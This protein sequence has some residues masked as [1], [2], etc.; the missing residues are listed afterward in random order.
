MSN[1]AFEKFANDAY[2]YWYAGELKVGVLAGGIPQD[3]NV[4]E[5]WIKT[6]L[7]DIRS[8]AEIQDVIATTMAEQGLSEEDAVKE[9][10][11]KMVGMNGFKRDETGLYV[12][13]RQL[14]AA[15]KEAVMVAANAG[16]LE[17][18]KWGKPDN[19]SY[20][21]QIKGWF[22]EHFF[23]VEER[24]YI[25]HDGEPVKVHDGVTQKFV[26]THRGDSISYEQ[27]V[28]DAEVRFTIKS[29]YEMKE[30]DWASIW[31]T[32]QMQGFGASRSQEYGRYI[33]TKWEPIPPVADDD[34]HIRYQPPESARV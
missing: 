17:T 34:S 25:R 5:S 31:L 21:K 4:V 30:K 33:V 6:K 16:K 32:G 15:L 20:R 19:A 18:G 1:G 24:L 7:R 22:P 2:P 3:P 10:S 9:A 13:G 14:K 28:R 8:E 29:D 11:V 27:F 23:I 26:H 12:E